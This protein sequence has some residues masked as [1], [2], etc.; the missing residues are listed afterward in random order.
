MS[1]T[2]ARSSL[3]LIREDV[4]GTTPATP[5][6]TTQRFASSSFGLSR[7]EL[8][9]NSKSDR[10]DYQYTVSG[11]NA[12]AG[13]ISAPFA[14]ENFDTLL[15]SA[16]FN[17]FD[18]VSNELKLGD[19]LQS[20]T[21]EEGQSDIGVYKQ[22]VG[23]VANGFTL[24]SSTDGLTTIDFDLLGLSESLS[25][26]SISAASYTAQPLR[27]PFTHCAGTITEG[28]V[29]AAYVNSISLTLSNNLE[30]QYNWGNCDAGNIVPNRIDVTGTLTCYMIDDVLLN[31]FRNG[32]ESSLQFTL[33]DRSGT[34]N[35]MTFKVPRIK[36]VSADNPVTESTQR[37]VTMNFRGLFDATDECSLMIT[38]N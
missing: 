29:A 1:A 12:I 6:L 4:F 35:T 14:H 21:I 17:T 36:Y 8:L 18:G 26:A 28:G 27:Q 11:N 33:N 19:N 30:A 7:Q 34:P 2:N 20:M 31:K 23:C 38:R 10:R 16:M 32:V 15:E 5:Q 3:A 9:D 22:Y 37:L 13:N 24:N 25:G